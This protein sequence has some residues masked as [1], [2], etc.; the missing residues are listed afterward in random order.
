MK[1]SLGW[2][3]L[4]A[5]ALLG[6][7]CKTYVYRVVQPPQS[8]PALVGEQPLQIKEPPLDYRLYRYKDHLLVHVVN[9]TDD[10]ITLQGNRSYVIDP[11]GESHPL[12]G[13]VLGPHSYSVLMLPPFPITAQVVGGYGPG[14][15][16]GGGWGWGWGWGPGIYNGFYG[17]WFYGPPIA[18]YQ[19]VTPYDWLWKE[20]PVRVRLSYEGENKHFTHD[21]EIV[22]EPKK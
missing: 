5:V 9:T 10:R 12:R 21:L 18:Y 13:R 4:L 1:A 6:G 3:W 19:L 22:R 8:G 15:G 20:G 7:G 17:D 11:Q 2:S 14:W 16:W